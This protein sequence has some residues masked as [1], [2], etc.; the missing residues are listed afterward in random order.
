M[1]AAR[2]L[3]GSGAKYE[4]PDTRNQIRSAVSARTQVMTSCR[5]TPSRGRRQPLSMQLLPQ[6]LRG[7]VFSFPCS[8]LRGTGF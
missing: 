1:E 5:Q 3:G 8:I 7:T 4:T 2:L 6:P